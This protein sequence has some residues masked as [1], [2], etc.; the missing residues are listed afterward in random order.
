MKEE[1]LK[2]AIDNKA[3]SI[4]DKI[5]N[6]KRDE[7]KTAV[8]FLGEFSSGKTS[9]VN[10]LLKKKFL[11]SFD[12]PT[13]AIVTEIRRGNETSFNILESS[14]G[15][16]TNKKIEISQIAEEVQKVNGNRV[17]QVEIGD[18]G[19]LDEKT[20]LIDTPGVSSI[21]ES[22]SKITYGYLPNM[23]VIFMVVNINMGSISK[24]LETFI[25]NCPDNIKEKLNFV[26]NFKDS[27]SPSQINHL[28]NEF[29]NSL[30]GYVKGAK[31]IVASSKEALKA[32]EINDKMMYANSGV[33]EIEDIIKTVIPNLHDEIAE[34]RYLESLCAIKEELIYFIQEKQKY[35][36]LDKGEFFDK[37]ENLKAEKKELLKSEQEIV[38]EIDAIKSG[39]IQAIT[40]LNKDYTINFITGL[41]NDDLEPVVIQ[42]TNEFSSILES[43]LTILENFN[44]PEGLSSKLANSTIGEINRKIG[45]TFQIVNKLPSIVNAGAL[46]LAT[47]GTSAIA[48]IAEYAI[49]Q[50]AGKAMELAEKHL[51]DKQA[52]EDA[53]KL[54]ADGKSTAEGV[55][56][57]NNKPISG[58]PISPTRRAVTSVITILNELNVTEFAKNKLTETFQQN[59]VY[60]ALKE[61][62]NHI[63]KD[64]FGG[65]QTIVSKKINREIKQPLKLKEE[66]ID[67]VKL[68]LTNSELEI[69]SAKDKAQRDLESLY[70]LV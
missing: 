50:G 48:N 26:L 4:I 54:I 59:N 9:L 46:A 68:E 65:V 15:K 16:Q 63:I 5:N 58:T 38:D 34:K 56:R 1:L 14:N 40:K 70:K 42:Y 47:G 53:I 44:L 57:N 11:P 51:E 69:K 25:Q 39:T 20:I 8:A 37:I 55:I 61:N 17:L 43:Q 27:K 13:T 31:I 36:S 23:D 33:Q 62:S 3:T 22:H 2:I 10:A 32:N 64:V 28:V 18:S 41:N 52:K 6:L 35:I 29:E 60:N 66:A 67:S 49:L 7:Y 12:K 30:K 45:N 21:N 19:L 24:S